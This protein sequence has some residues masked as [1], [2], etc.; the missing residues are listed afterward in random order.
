MASDAGWQ[1]LLRD[2]DTG[3]HIRIGDLILGSHQVP[4]TDPF[5]FSKPGQTWFAHEWLTS[6]LYA[7]LVRAGGLKALVLLTG[8]I[9]AFYNTVLL[10]DMVKRGANSLVA[11]A[12]VLAGTNAASIHF[13]TR[14]H[15]FTLLFL[16]LSS[17]L[18]AR[19]RSQPNR[20]IWLLVPMTVLWA[21]M[22]G[23]FVVLFAVLGIAVLG[24]LV[25]AWLNPKE[26]ASKRKMAVRY[27]GLTLV[28]GLASLLNP[29]G[30]KLHWHI[31]ELMQTAWYKTHIDE[32]RSPSF[33]SEP[34]FFFLAL[35]FLGLMAVY[36]L[37]RKNRITEAL[38]ILFFAY[39]SLVSA[40][41]IPL[42]IIVV[43]PWIALEITHVWHEITRTSS[44]Q[45]TAGVLEDIASQTS[46]KFG[47]FGLWTPLFVA[48][49]FLLTPANRWPSDF[50]KE[51]FPLAMLH[52]HAAELAQARVFTP[53]QWA[54]YLIYQNY[55]K[56]RVF[57]DGRSDYYGEEIGKAYLTMLEARPQWRELLMK[58]R[59][60]TVLCPP[61]WPLA[62][63]LK[64]NPDWRIADQ[65]AD[66]VLF[67]KN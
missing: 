15:V 33:T 55:P 52:R 1:A 34:M 27:A 40:R 39:W 50:S 22:H 16:T 13:H 57:L 23:G 4:T 37:L 53:D 58:Y 21:N 2:G 49:V 28:C 65:N 41:N 14:P 66:S 62:S 5:S 25:E 24:S 56:Q 44:P 36:P 48:G 38:W 3:I 30:V 59:F 18:I 46:R 29:Q 51:T 6:L 11:M 60:D 8:V 19:D 17:A 31:I 67:V 45:S 26:T 12:L 61:D 10:V 20:W 47:A 43:L 9:L 32:Y 35:L 7:G 64:T 63:L 54:D 42:F